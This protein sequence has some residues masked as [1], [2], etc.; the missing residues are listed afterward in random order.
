[1]ETLTNE[2]TNIKLKISEK[3]LSINLIKTYVINIEKN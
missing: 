1:M 3:K 2:N